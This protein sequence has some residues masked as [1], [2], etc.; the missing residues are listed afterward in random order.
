MISFFKRLVTP[1]FCETHGC[2]SF[3]AD[4]HEGLC[5]V[6]RLPSQGVQSENQRKSSSEKGQ[7]FS[8]SA[9]APGTP[10][11]PRCIVYGMTAAETDALAVKRGPFYRPCTH[12]FGTATVTDD[13]LRAVGFTAAARELP[14][15]DLEKVMLAAWL[16]VRVDQLPKGMGYH[17][18]TSTMQAWKRVGE[19][20]RAHVARECQ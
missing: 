10:E 4:P 11:E 8:D 17:P 20:A 3:H 2:N 19:A 9:N 6:C 7:L 5:V 18:N 12:D 16:N 1:R 14:R 13:E 15:D